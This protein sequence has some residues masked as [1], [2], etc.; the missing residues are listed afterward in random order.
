MY[1]WNRRKAEQDRLMELS[2]NDEIYCHLVIC[3]DIQNTQ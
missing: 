2:L 1:G 3:I